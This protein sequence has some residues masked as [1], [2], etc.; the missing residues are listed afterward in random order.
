VGPYTWAAAYASVG[1]KDKA[2]YWL[3]RSVDDHSCT[4]SE[5]NNDHGLDPLRSDPRFSEI[6]R[7]FGIETVHN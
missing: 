2:F 4:A 5:I 1:E 3:K 7:A 6:A